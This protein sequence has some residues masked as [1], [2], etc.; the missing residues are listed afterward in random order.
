MARTDPARELAST[1][2]QLTNHPDPNALVDTAL[3]GLARVD[4]WSTDF[5]LVLFE[6][7][8][9]CELV[10]L[11]IQRLPLDDDVKTD[12][13]RSIQRMRTYLNQRQIMTQ[14]ISQAKSLLGGQNITILKM[15][16][17]QVRENISYELLSS[18][19]RDD[20]LDDVRKLIGWLEQQQD[21]ETDFIR[22]ALIEGLQSF[23]F[24]LDRL[25][26]FG[27]GYVID[28]L[29]DVLHAYLALQGA[30]PE[31][32]NGDELLNAMLMKTKVFMG[33]AVKAFNFAKGTSEDA[34]WVLQVYGAAS[35]LNDGSQTISGFLGG[36]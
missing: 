18:D 22:Q 21:Q 10:E 15:L 1:L 13:V 29:K 6:L 26:W 19:Q 32:S 25:S 35:A 24:R 34:G 23:E 36:S 14:K 4:L 16:S 27:A 17:S 8:K 31:V 30:I 12:A 33:K 2:E 7:I 9:R 11:E 3:S 5:F 20:L 28:G